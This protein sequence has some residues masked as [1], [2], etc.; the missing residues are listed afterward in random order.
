MRNPVGFD[1]HPDTGT[2]YA[3]NNDPNH[4]GFE[5][6]PEHFS[7]LTPGSFLGMPWFRFDG[8]HLRRDDCIRAQPPTPAE[9]MERAL[10]TCLARSAPMAVVFVPL[11]ALAPDLE[12]DAIIALHGSWATRPQGC[13]S[14]D[15]AT[16][17][18]PKLARVRFKDGEVRVVEDLITGFQRRDGSR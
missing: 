5:L 9:A 1:R 8:E 13:A 3:S 6:P 4:W 16:W 15:P 14:G 10:A 2:L 17:R 18:E 12:G 7:R 11:G